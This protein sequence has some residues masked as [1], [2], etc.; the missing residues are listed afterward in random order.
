[1]NP[2]SWLYHGKKYYYSRHV[3]CMRVRV[4]SRSSRDMVLPS[5]RGR[6]ECILFHR[7]EW[8]LPSTCFESWYIMLRVGKTR[9]KTAFHI[10]LLWLKGGG[11]D[12]IRGYVKLLELSRSLEIPSPKPIY[13]FSELYLRVQLCPQFH[14]WFGKSAKKEWQK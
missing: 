12:K 13:F 9:R 4:R 14:K 6:V 11:L 10:G 7:L 3:K 1:M 5:L 2:Y 8:N